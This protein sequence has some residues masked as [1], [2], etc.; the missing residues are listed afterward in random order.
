MSALILPCQLRYTQYMNLTEISIAF[1]KLLI[2]GA[3]SFIVFI[4]LRFLVGLA[5][6]YVKSKQYTPPPL[7]NVRFNVLPRPQFTGMNSTS[8]YKFALQNIEGKPP[9]TTD[10]G[11][12]YSMP[13]KLP[14]LLSADRAKSF[15]SRIGFTKEPDQVQSIYYHYTDP[16]NPLRTLQLDIVNM[17]FTLTYDYEKNPALVFNPNRSISKDQVIDAVKSYI[18][19][20]GLMD[21]TIADGK[22]VGTLLTYQKESKDFTKAISIS[23]ADAVRIDFFRTDLDNMKMLPPGFDTSFNYALFSPTGDQLTN[24]LQ[25][26]YTYWPIA[27]DDFATYPFKSSIQA[28]QDLVDGYGFIVRL[29]NNTPDNIIIRNIYIAYY[30]TPQPQPYL[31][32]IFVFEG[33]NDFVAYVQAITSQWLE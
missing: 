25:L 13:K 23:A 32:P 15:A 4:M 33:D 28:W 8:G 12:V 1:R 18:S 16:T 31:Q 9:E 26:S 22:I 20:N 24:M 11:K 27:F 2:I 6:T 21:G 29:G 30:D 7:P 5:I 17:N 19:M 14:T 10:S 3:I